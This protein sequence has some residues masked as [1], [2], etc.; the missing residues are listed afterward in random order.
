MQGTTTTTKSNG[1]P[2][3]LQLNIIEYLTERVQYFTIFSN[4]SQKNVTLDVF[5]ILM[6]NNIVEQ[7]HACFI[8]IR[9]IVI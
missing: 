5:T 3:L 8:I 2:F 6:L 4:N 7:Y 9:N 1:L